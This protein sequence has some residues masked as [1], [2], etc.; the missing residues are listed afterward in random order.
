MTI[1]D[2]DYLYEKGSKENK[3]IFV[4]SSAR[5]MLAYPS[6]SE[7]VVEFTEPFTNVFGLEILDAAIPRTQYNI[8]VLNNKIVFGMGPRADQEVIDSPSTAYVPALDYGSSELATKLSDIITVNGC[9]INVVSIGTSVMT[10]ASTMPFAFNMDESTIS[11]CL[12]FE[13][14]AATNDFKGT[15]IMS[16]SSTPNYRI[17]KTNT[18]SYKKI[19]ASVSTQVS[20][21]DS[22]MNMADLYLVSPYAENKAVPNNVPLTSSA[23]A[24]QR[25]NIPA[26]D[27][28]H[29]HITGIQLQLIL[30]NIL[31]TSQPSIS[32][33]IY[34]TKPTIQSIPMYSGELAFDVIN[35]TALS[36]TFN[37]VYISSNSDYWIVFRDTSNITPSTSACYGI[38]TNVLMASEFSTTVNSGIIWNDVNSNALCMTITSNPLK[39]TIAPKCPVITEIFGTYYTTQSLINSIPLTI[40]SWLAEPLYIDKTN[41]DY[42][43]LHEL[44]FQVATKGGVDL[45]TSALIWSIYPCEVNTNI[46][47]THRLYSGPLTLTASTGTTSNL[48]T[49]SADL[50]ASMV[51]LKSHVLYWIVISETQITSISQCMIV[52]YNTTTNM[53]T[54]DYP[55]K[56]STWNGSSWMELSAS[57]ASSPRFACAKII[58][59]LTANN[60]KQLDVTT[61]LSSPYP[62]APDTRLVGTYVKPLTLNNWVA[63]YIIMPATPTC[64]TLRVITVQFTQIGIITLPPPQTFRWSIYLS[65]SAGTYPVQKL[66][67]GPLIIDPNTLVASSVDLSLNEDA[68]VVLR[69]DGIERYWLIIEDTGLNIDETQCMAVTYI[70]GGL[71][72]TS[73][74]YM[75]L[76]SNN[77]GCTWQKTCNNYCVNITYTHKTF[78]L[79]PPGFLSLV[80]DRFIILR[81]PEIERNI[82]GSVAFGRNSPGIALFK[83]GCVGYSDSRFDFSTVEYKEF[84]PI[85]KL[86][87][88]SFRFERLNGELYNFKAVNHHLMLV[89]KHY[90]ARKTGTLKHSTLNPNYTPNFINYKRYM[91]EHETSSVEDDEQ[92]IDSRSFKDVYLKKERALRDQYQYEDDENN[93]DDDENEEDDE[94]AGSDD[95]MKNNLRYVGNIYHK[96]YRDTGPFQDSSSDED[97]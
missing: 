94:D 67:S 86:P 52:Q 34:N 18:N 54:L 8:D 31:Y 95:N 9:S 2:I 25:I 55:G 61:V 32:W 92:Y 21:S 91:E 71:P 41:Y 87:R 6:P 4:D 72:D 89:V 80:G 62:I 81:C 63:Q 23:W 39:F 37:N 40:N 82:G 3:V 33:K 36:T 28:T 60:L 20:N 57:T 45:S 96:K 7:Y 46:P 47:G 29:V 35:M 90:V 74:S 17:L 83:M 77:G 84:H 11:E 66:F 50:T 1:E 26:L 10:F 5:D 97:A 14:I 76:G 19:Y 16:S 64:I 48:Y 56:C 85:G 58:W 12:G 73:N 49:A 22:I 93:E 30:R 59:V 38:T 27:S 43:T 15:Q 24:M 65:S 51:V 42:I 44:E 88:L 78:T 13:Y 53:S 75:G 68:L 69:N 70:P 79:T